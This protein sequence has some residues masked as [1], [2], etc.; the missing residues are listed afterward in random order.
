VLELRESDVRTHSDRVRNL[1]EGLHALGVPVAMEHFG[2]A[3]DSVR[4]LRELKPSYIKVDRSLTDDL[5]ARSE[6][7]DRLQQLVSQAKSHHVQTMAGY[8]EDAGGLAVLWQSGVV[9]VQGH[10]LDHPGPEIRDTL[11]PEGDWFRVP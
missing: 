3:A 4:L 9:L 5:C 7:R 6:Q 2:V 8:V 10:F 11:G 1:I